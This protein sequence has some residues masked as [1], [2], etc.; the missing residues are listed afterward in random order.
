MLSNT[1]L[2]LQDAGRLRNEGGAQQNAERSDMVRSPGTGAE[3]TKWEGLRQVHPYPTRREMRASGDES[4]ES[5]WQDQRLNAIHCAG[6]PPASFLRPCRIESVC[7]EDVLRRCGRHNRIAANLRLR[8][9][10][11]LHARGIHGRRITTG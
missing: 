1:R 7:S 8:E 10:G 2:L 3:K 9:G 5:Y 6:Q 4:H 11:L